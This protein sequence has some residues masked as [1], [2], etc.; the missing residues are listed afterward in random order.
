M[1][2]SS[3]TL[4]SSIFGCRCR[5]CQ[6]RCGHS[7][8]HDGA[9]PLVLLS[10]PR[11]SAARRRILTLSLH[12]LDCLQTFHILMG[13]TI[14]LWG[15]I[16]GLAHLAGTFR[17]SCVD[18]QV[19]KLVHRGDRR[20]VE[21]RLIC[22]PNCSGMQGRSVP[23]AADRRRRQAM[24]TRLAGDCCP[25]ASLFPLLYARSLTDV[26]VGLGH[27]TTVKPQL[28]YVTR[29]GRH[30]ERMAFSHLSAVTVRVEYP[31]YRGPRLCIK[32]LF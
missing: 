19:I 16:H 24:R 4:P 7:V 1:P 13:W 28:K 8:S 22:S 25:C 6:V 10:P 14:L 20:T 5:S 32:N 15:T 18:Q 30:A 3:A 17:G 9:R 26:E 12:Q 11:D 29:C 21:T 2:S 31:R 23:T 27:Q